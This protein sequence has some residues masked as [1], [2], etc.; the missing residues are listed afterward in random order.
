MD[1]WMSKSTNRTLSTIR[2]GK[3]SKYLLI[4]NVF[5]L[6]FNHQILLR[7]HFRPLTWLVL[8]RSCVLWAFGGWRDIYRLLISVPKTWVCNQSKCHKSRKLLEKRQKIYH[9]L[10]IILLPKIYLGLKE[11]KTHYWDFKVKILIYRP[12]PYIL[13]LRSF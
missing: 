10:Y 11:L 6:F 12:C 5:S 4:E 13:C 1:E 7:F 2:V 8:S 9:V 3:R